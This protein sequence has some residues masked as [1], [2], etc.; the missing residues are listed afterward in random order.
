LV[1]AYVVGIVLEVELKLAI[2]YG[3]DKRVVTSTAGRSIKLSN[4]L[5]SSDTK[6]RKSLT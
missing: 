4:K 1:F 2:E 5:C 3:Q 6:A